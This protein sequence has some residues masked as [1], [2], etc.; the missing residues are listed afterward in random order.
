MSGGASVAQPDSG[1]SV[2]VCVS[3]AARVLCRGMG[4]RLLAGCGSAWGLQGLQAAACDCV[5]DPCGCCGWVTPCRGTACA[6]RSGCAC[7]V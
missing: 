2:C 1:C 3:T 4:K 7:C 6:G 5:C